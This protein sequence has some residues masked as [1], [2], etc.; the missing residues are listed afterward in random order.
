MNVILQMIVKTL[1]STIYWNLYVLK[2][3]KIT[4]HKVLLYRS[5]CVHCGDRHDGIDYFDWSTDNLSIWPH[6][7]WLLHAGHVTR[8]L[9]QSRPVCL[10]NQPALLFF[11]KQIWTQQTRSLLYWIII[12][13][14]SLCSSGHSWGAGLA[15]RPLLLIL[16]KIYYY[17]DLGTAKLQKAHKVVGPTVY[18][19]W[20]E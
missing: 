5:P 9:F 17:L 19:L 6:S 10:A 14:N 18:L 1:N 15:S 16:S 7:L 2:N 20:A 11:F 3:I 4:N 13:L 12:Q 8:R